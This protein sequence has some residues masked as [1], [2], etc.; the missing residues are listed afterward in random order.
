MIIRKANYEDVKTLNHFLTLLI[1]EEKQYDDGID[2]TFVVTTMY[3]NY[4]EDQSKFIFVAEE[5]NKIVGYLY[6]KIRPQD[7]TYKDSIAVLDALYVEENYRKRGIAHA[8][9]EHFKQWVNSKN[10]HKIEVSVWSNNTKAKHLYEK[11][12]FKTAKETLIMNLF[13]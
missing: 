11:E 2:D 10:I 7:E 6:G 3:E 1:R 12:N 4:I 5:E 8:R 9:I 13:D